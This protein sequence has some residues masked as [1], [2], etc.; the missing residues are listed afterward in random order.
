VP[1]GDTV[2]WTVLVTNQGPSAATHVTLDD[3]LP[4]GLTLSSAEAEPPGTCTGATCDLG[5][6]DAGASTSVVI[7][8]SSTP[9]LA[10]Q[11]LTNTA[12][13]SSD[14]E[15]TDPDDN[16]DTAR[17]TF[18]PP[19]VTP[20][21]DVA[22][23]KT[24]DHAVVNVGD[25]VTYTIT[26]T[27]RGTGAAPHAIVAENPDPNLQIVSVTPSQGACS[28]T[29]PVVCNLGPLA[30]GAHATVIVVARPL[31]SGTLTN[32]VVALPAAK[33][34]LPEDEADIDAVP[35]P[36]VR[37]KKTA[38]VSTVHAGDNVRFF[39]TASAHGRG[40]AHQVQVCDNVPR[41]LLVI[42]AHGAHRIGVR[43]C[44][45][46]AR[47][48]GGQSRTFSLDV[49]ALATAQSTTLVNHALLNNGN[50]P[51]QHATASVRVLPTAARFTG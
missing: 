17:V 9:E 13:V 48:A 31:A 50:R 10:G 43:W 38:S 33:P 42:N 27:N 40:L 19:S 22:V 37:L 32:G 41:G 1:A 14:Q 15:E 8:A 24:A 36:D 34:P 45:T 44:W 29:V 7:R 18:G 26:A 20:A 49:R 4:P 23:T 51:Q 5:R 47:L 16:T 39:L 3:A 21:P 46:I 25:E 30:P 6:L 35:A 2:T 12:T 11:T 28:A